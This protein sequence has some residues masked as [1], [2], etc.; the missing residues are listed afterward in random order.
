MEAIRELQI[1][2]APTDVRYGNFAGGLV[3]AVTKSGSNQ[4]EGSLST[5]F[6]NQALTGRRTPPAIAR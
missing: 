5:Y 3:N 1:L 2:I 6:Q 4:W